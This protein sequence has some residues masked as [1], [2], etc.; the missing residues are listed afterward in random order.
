[1]HKLGIIGFPLTHSFSKQYFDE[2]FGKEQIAGWQFERFPLEKIE[3]IS[4]LLQDQSLKGFCVTIP[5]KKKIIHYLYDATDAVK[6]MVACNCVKIA[7]GKLYGYNTDVIGFEQSFVKQ[8]QPHHNK[9]LILGTGGA[10]HAVAYALKHLGIEYLFVSRD[11]IGKQKTIAYFDLTEALFNE[12]TIII[13]ATPVGSFPDVDA[14]PNI[15]Y[16]YITVK[17]YLF[18]VIYN[19]SLTA[20]LQ[21]GKEQGA[22]IQNGYEMLVI[23][24]EENWKIWSS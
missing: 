4:D 23:Q 20:F 18:D 21:K 16:Q 24:A 2:K 17:H 11:K 19:P 15:P 8:L 3:Q 9:A 13:N 7:D 10:A 22:V 14:Y 5:Y 6:Q 12:F 1:M